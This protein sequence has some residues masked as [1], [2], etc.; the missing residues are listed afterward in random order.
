MTKKTFYPN[1]VDSTTGNKY[2]SFKDLKNIKNETTSY[3]ESSDL[4]HGKSKTPNRPAPLTLSNFKMNIPTGSKI[5]SVTVEYSH[6][7]TEFEGKVPNIPGPDITLGKVVNA[8]KKG[9]APTAVFKKNSVTFKPGGKVSKNSKKKIGDITVSKL[10]NSNFNVH[11]N[12]PANTNKHEGKLQIRFVRIIVDYTEPTYSFAWKKTKGG[13]NEEECTVQL[14]MNNSKGN[15]YNP[16]CLVT[17]PVGF[18]LKSHSGSGK[19]TRVDAVTYRWVP[20]FNKGAKKATRT[21]TFD[22]DVT[23]ANNTSNYLATFNVSESLKNTTSSFTVE[24]TN[25]PPSTGDSGSDEGDGG[26]NDANFKKESEMVKTLK[27]TK[28][29]P[30]Y[31]NLQYQGDF[32][33]LSTEYDDDLEEF[34]YYPVRICWKNADRWR[35]FVDELELHPKQNQNVFIADYFFNSDKECTV[36]V[37][38]QTPFYEDTVEFDDSNDTYTGESYVK[39]LT[40]DENEEMDGQEYYWCIFNIA[41]E[42]S[43]LIM[44]NLALLEITG[45]EL[46]RL[47]DGRVYNAETFLKVITEQGGVNDW[48]KNYRI[49]VFN[50]PIEENI[51]HTVEYNVNGDTCEFLVTLPASIPLS[52]SYWLKFPPHSVGGTIGNNSMVQIITDYTNAFEVIKPNGSDEKTFTVTYENRNDS[53][54]VLWQENYV[55][56]FNQDEESVVEIIND[57]TDYDNLT[58]LELF[59]NAKSWSD[60]PTSANTF[61]ELK[62]EFDYEED[63]PLFILISSDYHENIPYNNSIKFLEPCIIEEDLYKEREKNGIFPVPI[64]SVISAQGDTEENTISTAEMTIPNMVESNVIICSDLQFGE[65][66]STDEQQAIRGIQI[67]ADV[68]HSDDLVVYA[69]LISPEGHLTGQRSSILRSS[70]TESITEI[71]LGSA[72]DL[73][74]FVTTDIQNLENWEIQL[75]FSNLLN[76][77]EST[78]NFYNLQITAFVET[79]EDQLITCK[80]EGQDLRYFGCFLTN[81]TIPEGLKTNTEYI[82]ISGTDTNDPYMQSIKE[83]TIEIEFDISDSCD[84]E[85]N[86]NVLQ[87]LTTLLV[88]ERDKYKRPL[89]KKIEFSHYPGIYWE[90]I[91]EDTFD[92]DTDISEYSVKLKLTIPAGTA[93]SSEDIVTNTTGFVNGIASVQPIIQFQ[94]SES[95]VEVEEVVSEQKFSLGYPGEWETKIVEIDCPNQIVWLLDDENDKEPTDITQYI[96]INSDWFALYGEYEFQATNATIRTITFTE[97]W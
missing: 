53:T 64:K 27:M 41:P 33:D 58:T 72:I 34:V 17:T 49:G 7:K 88:N 71:E 40:W 82:N 30:F 44:P 35:F 39:D 22:V 73:W 74:G 80:V 86:T 83:K 12:Y 60:A 23:Y 28:G 77:G 9:S 3:A 37:I 4:I 31:L 43:D 13:Y 91:M 18:S 36:T 66:F 78:I 90:Y 63:Y 50:N 68:E 96:D 19:L 45:E 1:T 38:P 65:N 15:K 10:N 29:E 46:D 79:I 48:N 52:D 85:E 54:D 56:H 89:P 87:Q 61:E 70:T 24:I 14:Q 55:I 94:P 51:T 16:T 92:I 2:R 26:N 84:I 67:T 93:F 62:A 8:T 57:I 95:T 47:Q 81:V 21:F 11:F 69:K 5:N 25:R 20:N 75:Q 97:R 42:E 59:E 32:S 76:P 6:C